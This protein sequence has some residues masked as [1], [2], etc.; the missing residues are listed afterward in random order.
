MKNSFMLAALLLFFTT[1]SAQLPSPESFLGYKVGTRFT[2]HWKIV[3]YF[4]K[5]AE[6]LPGR[7]RLEQYGETNEHRP[8]Y[9][10]IIALEENM[11]RLD[12]IR[13]NN[14]RLAQ[15]TNDKALP[16]E[17]APAIVWLSFNVH[18]NEASSSEASMLTLYELANPANAKSQAWL[19][20]TVIII[21]PCINPDGRDRYVN[22]YNSMVG[23]Q[24]DARAD[25]RE[26]R[27][28]WPGG[29]TNHYNFDL[30]RDWVWQTQKESRARIKQ[31]LQW[32][33]Q[34]HVDY[35][36]QGYN[37]PYYFAP[38]AQPYHDVI[39]EWQR[40]FQQ[41]IG[42]NHARYFDKNG[43]LY[44]TRETFD[45]LYPS[46]GDT[47][48][49]YNGAIGMTYEQGGSGAAG[50]GVVTDEKDTLTLVDRVTHHFTTA[51]S[52]VET[53]AQHA[54]ELIKQ[55]RGYF[56]N[57]VKGNTGEYKTYIIRYRAQDAERIREFCQLLDRNG[58]RYGTGKGQLKA[59]NYHS[60]KEENI[61][62]TANDIVLSNAQPRAA[63]LQV[64]MEPEPRLTDSL[65][66]DIT[67]WALPYA[68]GLNA[69]A[70][71]QSANMLPAAPADTIR[72]QPGDL[73]GY[74]IRW[75]GMSSARVVTQLLKQGIR[76]RVTEAGFTSNGQDFAPGSVI[77]LKN[78]NEKFGNRLWKI[79]ATACDSEQVKMHLVSSGMVDKG[80]DFGSSKVQQ[81]KPVRVG[82]MTGE[83]VSSNAAGEVW[84][85]FEREL[86]YPLSLFNATD[87]SRIS[88]NELD[89][90]ILP[91]GNYRFLQDK[92]ASARLQEW[93]AAGGKVVAL[94]SAVA[95][96]ARLE[97]SALKERSD[98]G[99]DTAEKSNPYTPLK[100]FADREKEQITRYTPGSVYRVDV[101]STHPLMYGFPSYYYTLKMD[102][103]VYDYIKS[104]GWNAG[105]IKK[106]NQL[107]GF[108]GY[109]LKKKLQDGLVF[110]VQQL[111]RGQVVFL[112]DNVLFRN[113]WENGKLM[114]ANA[115]LMR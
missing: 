21:D 64:L 89:V 14:L 49:I 41:T 2:P 9:L 91:E 74:V 90:L 87:F 43:W 19:N 110:G 71:R 27:E 46:Y 79:V 69:Y 18:G 13:L 17:D 109:R 115:V 92:S 72:N 100:V 97:W 47:Y 12:A 5:I 88:W 40:S 23:D 65:T 82:L 77:I 96:L 52:T 93:V 98:S 34:I 103:V 59:I 107:A 61:S 94:E 58:I 101:D 39:T 51:L 60:G 68:Y 35:H 24:F 32:M 3:D 86:N 76:L 67:A 108:V 113:F 29:R 63:M 114:M 33:P 42:R 37:S 85:F 6:T 36:E 56:E 7:V 44:F 16:T 106:D 112:T 66:Y 50:L 62:I 15:L 22:W 80:F 10:A 4:Q 38:A 70:S 25:S 1:L 105:V 84:H 57:A 53:A 102:D 54:P 81:I 95:Q 28:P 104:G 73:Y 48:P 30:N 20:N 75:R 55:F 83:G 11:Q 45:L 8:L 99:P 111:G 26:H 78:G 31:Y